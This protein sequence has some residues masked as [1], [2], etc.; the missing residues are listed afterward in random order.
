MKA[1]FSGGDPFDVASRIAQASYEA[2]HKVKIR[3]AIK[4]PD[5]VRFDDDD[6]LFLFADGLS[7]GVIGTR[8]PYYEQQWMA[9]RY[10]PNPFHSPSDKVQTQT[11]WGKSWLKVVTAPVPQEFA[12]FPQY[13]SGF[14]SFIER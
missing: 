5:E 13:Q 4:T 14:W 11:R 12:H 8:K 9:G 10:H 7:G 3:R 6:R 1:L 2:G